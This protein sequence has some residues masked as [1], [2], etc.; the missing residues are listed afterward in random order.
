MNDAFTELFRYNLWATLGLLDACARL[1][2]AVLDATTP[3]TY[4]SIRATFMH[5]IG[6]EQRYVTLLRREPRATPLEH[7]EF[8]GFERLRAL[9]RESGE[10]LIALAEGYEPGAVLHVTRDDEPY[11]LSTLIPLMQAIH[12]GNDHRSHIN[13]LLGVQGIEPP[14]LDV[15]EYG[16]AVNG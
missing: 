16:E 8:P 2:D 1:D 5:L 3:G 9:A 7:S 4:G 10:A 6:A 13:T 14:D 11:E 12:H 15:W